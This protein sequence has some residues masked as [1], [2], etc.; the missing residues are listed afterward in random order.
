MFA[1]KPGGLFSG[2]ATQSTSRLSL[3]VKSPPLNVTCMCVFPYKVDSLVSNLWAN[4]PQ[5]LKLGVACLVLET[6]GEVSS[7]PLRVC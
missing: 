7:K 3:I 4:K 5:L 2:G 1:T 6:R